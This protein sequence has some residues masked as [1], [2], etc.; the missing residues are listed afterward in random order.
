MRVLRLLG[1]ALLAVGV[2]VALYLLMVRWGI[3]QRIDDIA[4]EGRKATRLAPRRAASRVMEVLTPVALVVG[5]SAMVLAA[6]RLRGRL[7]A[8]VIAAVLLLTGIGSRVA[9]ARLPREDLLG[10][11][12]TG[13]ANTYPS[14]HVAVATALVLLAVAVCPPWW[15]SRVAAL[16][17][18]ALSLHSV[19]MMGSGWHRPSDVVGGMALA[20]AVG[21]LGGLVVSRQWKGSPRP[22]GGGWFDRPS[23]V[24]VGCGLFLA[25]AACWYVPIRLLSTGSAGESGFRSHVVLAVLS[26][27]AAV[28][29]TATHAHL[30][31]RLDAGRTDPADRA[32]VPSSVGGEQ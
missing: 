31:H 6:W 30:L 17:A 24:L 22:V 1:W 26:G 13:P 23:S 29:V 19:A 16:G 10:D 20:T 27:A 14:G 2:F 3:G 21:A 25:A 5:G 12:F 8:A 7:S 15:R 4:M 18:G 32:A 9:K 28:V 11:S